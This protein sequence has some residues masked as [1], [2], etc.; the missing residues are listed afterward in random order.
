MEM[1]AERWREIKKVLAG[2]LEQTPEHRRAYLDQTCTDPSLRREVESLLDADDQGVGSFIPGTF[3]V[4]ET[5]RN[6]MRF[7]S[8]TIVRQLGAGGMGEV[9]EAYD[10]KLGRK[11]AIK[12]LPQALLDKPARLARFQ[13]E[14]RL[15]ASLNH[16]NICTIHDVGEEGGH[17]FI[18]M[19]SLDGQTLKQL[20]S[21]KPLPIEKVLD[22]GT[23]IADALDAAHAKG[24]VHRDIKPSNIF[25]TERGHA[26]ILDFGLA[27]LAPVGS[28][29]DPSMDITA[30]GTD[31][32]THAGGAV[33]TISY[34]SPEQ[35]RGEEIDAR[36]D[37]FSFGVVLYEMSTGVL[38]FRGETSGVITEAILNR[39]PV[40]PVRLNPDVPAKLE[41]V[42]SKAL[43][44]DRK[45]RYQTAAEMRTDLQR[46]KRD[47]DSSR[48]TTTTEI[49]PKPA[50]KSAGLRWVAAAVLLLALGA[51]GWMFFSRRAHGRRATQL[52]SEKQ[53]AV[54]QFRAVDG[55]PQAASFTAGLSDTLTAKLTELTGDDSLEVVPASEVQNHHV[56]T[57]EE[58][59]ADFGVNLVLE[60]S[61]VKS[62]DL[63]RVN[64]NLVDARTRREIKADS[65]TVASADPFAVQDR[66]V[67]SV[68]RM[69]E[70]EVQPAERQNLAAHGTSVPAAYGLYLEGTGYLQNYDEPENIESAI[71]V[72]QQALTLDPNYALAYAGLGS[73]YWKKYENSKDAQWVN[74]SREA[75]EQAISL[76]VNL[77]AA[78]VC[79][80]AV[81]AGTGNYDQATEELERAVQAEPTNDAAYR[82]LAQAYE[83][84]GKPAEAEKIYQRAVRLRPD[85]WAGYSWLGAFYFEQARYADAEKMF[86]KVVMLAPDSFR[87]YYNLG[88]IELG[89]GRYEDAVQELKHSIAIRPSSAAYSNLGTTYFYLR[90]Y[91]Q[92]VSAY[93][94]AVKLDDKDYVVWW[95]L[96]DATYWTPSRRQ[97]APAAYHQAI[98]LAQEALQVNPR[99]AYALSVVAICEAML[100]EK[101]QA[102]VALN[103]ALGQTAADPELRFRAAIVYCQL[104]DRSLALA[105]LEKAV[106]AGFERRVVRDSPNFDSLQTD[107][108]FIRLIKP[109]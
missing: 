89:E 60:G 33:G 29:S 54:L 85:Y 39:T 22:L 41:A 70:L 14:A 36:S 24:I 90:R 35:V 26:K 40:P 34:M 69:L 106:S 99:D 25:V 72:F 93:A 81:D 74:K 1:T 104:D 77:V 71:N 61:L 37:L 32:V 87:G 31:Q 48:V 63:V 55:D 95:N 56:T 78:R 44:K 51:G 105:S 75:C 101:T 64:C 30:S 10:S 82:G 15:L 103:R 62:G 38:P 65:I 28:E 83:R 53:L 12:V 16:P 73:S 42:I 97:E 8:Y 109:T 92:A 7:G 9:Y 57:I 5:L 67:S 102:L 4:S 76:D 96:G 43:E 20:I 66:V 46:L 86:Q 108:R 6:G 17:K 107:P 47:S 84:L 59:S 98:A 80:G 91:D 68:I 88:A 94:E 19:E 50:T 49:E 79:L 18:A 27:K 3:A 11:L 58:A 52:P 13:R 2:A 23:E 45:L 21:S 100:G